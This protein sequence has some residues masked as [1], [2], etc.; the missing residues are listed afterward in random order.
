M[1]MPALQVSVDGRPVATVATEGYNVVSVNVAGTKTDEPFAHLDVSGGIYPDD[2]PS[3][4]LVW[5]NELALRPGQVV[6]VSLL[7]SA[8]SSHSGKT[9]AELFPDQTHEEPTPSKAIS[10]VVEEL[11]LRPRLH[12]RYAFVFATSNGTNYAGEA[13]ASA[14]GFGFSVLWNWLQPERVSTSLHTYTLDDL[15]ERGSMNY[16]AREYILAEGEA[17]LDLVA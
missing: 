11:R 6:T 13:P 1:N 7:E 2:G 8:T 9:I 4:Y 5:V 12:D 15:K 17:R 10:E 3:T 16:L 14:H